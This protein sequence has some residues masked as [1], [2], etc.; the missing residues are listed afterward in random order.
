MIQLN[1]NNLLHNDEKGLDIF[2]CVKDCNF[3]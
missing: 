3:V 1:Q 2:L